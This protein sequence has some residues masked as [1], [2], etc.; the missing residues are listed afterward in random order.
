MVVRSRVGA[1][2]DMP[3]GIPM[4]ARKEPI[5]ENLP[6]AN[7]DRLVNSGVVG[8]VGV[9]GVDDVDPHTGAE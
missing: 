8:I 9:G 2:D 3:V 5:E 4:R 1:R 6:T 7:G